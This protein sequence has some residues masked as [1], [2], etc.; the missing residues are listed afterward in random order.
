M[1]DKRPP[2]CRFRLQDE[3]KAHPKSSCAA[4][5]RTISTGLGKACHLMALAE[6][7]EACKDAASVYDSVAGRR[8]NDV[9]AEIEENTVPHD[10]KT[11]AQ[12]RLRHL[13]QRGVIEFT[14]GYPYLREPESIR[15]EMFQEA[16]DS[17]LTGIASRSGRKN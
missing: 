1:P 12:A 14:N 5:G 6:M 2:N 9:T 7:D 4:C 17:I 8:R 3:G 10:L 15:K 16:V 11:Q 13:T